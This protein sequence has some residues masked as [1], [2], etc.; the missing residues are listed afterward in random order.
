V[1][2]E[3]VSARDELDILTPGQ[4]WAYFRLARKEEERT[5]GVV[6]GPFVLS[7]SVLFFCEGFDAALDARQSAGFGV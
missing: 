2:A 1:G 4:T 6:V 5:R 3:P 7:F